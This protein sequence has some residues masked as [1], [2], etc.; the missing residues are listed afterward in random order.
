MST[1]RCNECLDEGWHCIFE[2]TDLDGPDKPYEDCPGDANWVKLEKR[3]APQERNM[4][5]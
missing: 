3:Q 4:R 2:T 5:T 1:W